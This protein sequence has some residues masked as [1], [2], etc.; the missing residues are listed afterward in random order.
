MNETELL[1]T[2]LD[3]LG[4]TVPD[5]QPIVMV[6][7][8]RYREK[9]NYPAGTA[10]ESTTGRAAY[11]RYSELVIRHRALPGGCGDCR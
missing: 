1:R 9:A 8:L 3:D 7:L 6:N 4:K 10:E 11:Q 5:N 2:V